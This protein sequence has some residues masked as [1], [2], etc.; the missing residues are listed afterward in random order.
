MLMLMFGKNDPFH[1]G[2]IPRAMFTYLRL[3]TLDT[4]D[5]ILNINLYGCGK[6]PRG[7]PYLNQDHQAFQCDESLKGGGWGAVFTFLFAIVIG[8]CKLRA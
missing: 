2:S 7:Y 1:F 6:F 8:A 3:E 5:E 4:W